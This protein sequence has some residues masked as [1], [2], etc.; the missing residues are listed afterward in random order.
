MILHHHDGRPISVPG[1]YLI[2]FRD[3]EG[4]E[5][6]QKAA[7]KLAE[8]MAKRKRG[9][10]P[11]YLYDFNQLNERHVDKFR[12]ATRQT[13][14]NKATVSFVSRHNQLFADQ[15]EMESQGARIP[16]AKRISAEMTEE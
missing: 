13:Q 14:E 12:L 16:E 11:Y 1:R 8:K 2:D 4:D 15:K 3:K 6:E 10:P 9:V 7:R 5:M